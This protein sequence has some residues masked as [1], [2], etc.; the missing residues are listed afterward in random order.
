MTNQTAAQGTETSGITAFNS[1]GWTT[2]AQYEI[3]DSASNYA[4]W[5]FRK[6][7]K[8]FDV[9][10]YNGTGSNTTIAHN[11]GSGP[12]SI[13]VKRT[14][15]TSAWS[16]YHRSLANTQYL[17]LNTTAAAATG[18]TWWNSTT[19]TSSVFSVG[20]DA[21]VNGYGDT[22][23]AYLFAHDAGGFGLAGTD[24]V[25][26]CGS[27]TTDGSGDATVNLGYEPQWVLMKVTN[28]S[29]DWILND[30]MRGMPTKQ[31]PDAGGNC[32]NL[33]PNTS[34]AESVTGRDTS[35]TSTGFIARV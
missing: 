6:Q 10:T 27:F 20:T 18:A 31:I 11:L 12:G 29:Q 24:N 33:F 1:N 15:T 4:S 3:N 32:V 22:Y 28:D 2:G 5:T 35:P 8:F 13:I 34:G 16:V 21:T 19:P 17:V 23:V 26:S 9:V 30:T 25:V 14:N 7:P